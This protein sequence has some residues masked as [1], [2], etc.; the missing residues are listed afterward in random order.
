MAEK[1]IPDIKNRIKQVV[2]NLSPVQRRLSREEKPLESV[3][4]LSNVFLEQ[5]PSGKARLK[6]SA[7]IFCMGAERRAA[8]RRDGFSSEVADKVYGPYFK[9]ASKILGE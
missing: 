8:V 4:K 3:T 9:L 7:E 2:Q 6:F 5:N 1:T